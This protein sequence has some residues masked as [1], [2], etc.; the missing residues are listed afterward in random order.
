MHK[1]SFSTIASALQLSQKEVHNEF[2]VA[3]KFTQQNKVQSLN[4]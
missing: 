4:Y 1:Q 2:I 3:Y